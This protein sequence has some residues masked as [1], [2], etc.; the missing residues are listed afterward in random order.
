[1]KSKRS[2][3]ILVSLLLLSVNVFSAQTEIIMA[4]PVQQEVNQETFVANN[5]MV[6]KVFD[7]IAERLNKPIILSKLAAQKRITGNFNLAHADEMFKALTRR[8]ALVWYDDGAAIYVYDNSEMRSAII[9]MN[10]ASS[11]QVLNYIKKNG[12][13]D[14]RF[15]VRTQGGNSLL[16]VSGP[17]LYVELIQAATAYLDEQVKQEALSGGELAVIAVK[18]ASVTDRTYSLR[19]NN[20]TVPGMLSVISELFKNTPVG[21][22]PTQKIASAPKDNIGDDIDALMDAP[23]GEAVEPMPAFNGTRNPSNVLF[24]LVA[25]PDSNSLIVKGSP[26][27]IRYVRQLVRTLDTRRRQVELSLWI[28]D[29]TRSELDNLGVNWEVGTINTGNSSFSFNRSTLSDS[30]DFLLRIDA[31]SKSG[32]GQYCV[33]PRVINSRKYSCFI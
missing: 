25:H 10:N 29:I 32:N 31:L 20:I 2:G 22:V 17:P 1:M 13:Y 11:H 21:T 26:E 18:Y 12:I 28:I 8:I 9:P 4:E 23:I 5:I 14:Q 15:P 6:G 33:S 3:M 24:S 27:Q 19:G 7:A 30:T 16:F